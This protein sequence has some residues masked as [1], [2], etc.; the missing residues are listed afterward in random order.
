V[1]GIILIELLYLFTP[2]KEGA[3]MLIP[4]M[5][6]LVIEV[7]QNVENKLTMT[8]TANVYQRTRSSQM[9]CVYSVLV[10]YLMV[11]SCW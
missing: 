8:G 5:Y 1:Q 10:L 7:I 6:C 2:K 9:E 3:G 11:S 4:L